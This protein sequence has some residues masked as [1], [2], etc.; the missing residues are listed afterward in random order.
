MLIIH[1]IFLNF[2]VK[3]RGKHFLTHIIVINY[4]YELSEKTK[5]NFPQLNRPEGAQK[6]FVISHNVNPMRSHEVIWVEAFG[7]SR[8]RIGFVVRQFAFSFHSSAEE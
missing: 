2:I 6:F 4:L 7:E 3:L 8:N 5:N 1:I